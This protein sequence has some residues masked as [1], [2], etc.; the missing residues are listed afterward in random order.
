MVE[1]TVG[2]RRH[3]HKFTVTLDVETS[4]LPYRT[5]CL[6]LDRPIRR[7][8]VG[9]EQ[10]LRSSLHARHVKRPVFMTYASCEKAWT[11]TA[12]QDHIT[13]FASGSGETRMKVR[14]NLADPE[15]H[16]FP[17]QITVG[18]AQPRI[19]AA[20]GVRIEVNYLGTGMD[21]GISTSGNGHAHRL[22]GNLPERVLHA[23]LD[24]THAILPLPAAETRAVVFDDCRHTHGGVFYMHFRR[25]Q[26]A[27]CAATGS[28]ATA[29]RSCGST[30]PNL[31][32][33]DLVVSA[34]QAMAA[35]CALADVLVNVLTR[36]K[37]QLTLPGP[38]H[39]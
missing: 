28:A 18:S 10:R 11:H 39:Q 30:G 14:R 29:A 23:T 13:V 1:K 25:C 35:Q 34:R 32:F 6:A 12:V 22:V 3:D 31:N 37:R 20:D 36:A 17:G 2:G 4:Q 24:R 19:V 33:L 15:Q 27:G 26:L 38:K 8:I 5:F 16:D 21:A 7:E 9:A